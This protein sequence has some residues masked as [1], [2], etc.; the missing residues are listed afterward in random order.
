M[1]GP[2]DHFKE[3]P[4]SPSMISASTPSINSHGPSFEANGSTVYPGLRFYGKV[5]GCMHQ[6]FLTT[7]EYIG[8]FDWHLVKGQESFRLRIGAEDMG[9][10][11]DARADAVFTVN[12]TGRFIMGEQSQDGNRPVENATVT[13]SD[14][15]MTSPGGIRHLAKM[16]IPNAQE[17]VP[18]LAAGW[19]TDQAKRVVVNSF[20][21]WSEHQPGGSLLNIGVRNKTIPGGGDNAPGITDGRTNLAT[22]MQFDGATGQVTVNLG[23]QS[24]GH[25]RNVNEG[26]WSY[27]RYKSVAGEFGM[28]AGPGPDGAALSFWDYGVNK[29]I[30]YANAA[31][32]RFEAPI[33]TPAPAGTESAITDN[34]RASAE[35]IR[36]ALRAYE[37]PNGVRRFGITPAAVNE[38][39]TSAGLDPAK[40]DFIQGDRVTI[41]LWAFLAAA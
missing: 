8:E 15:D 11:K 23:D 1:T 21:F 27:E 28:G 41:D 31:V 38:A 25:V 12:A 32:V 18:I 14:Y 36:S 35:R 19:A 40:Y 34:E 16:D 17:G 37:D 2:I 29:P 26:N 4:A 10:A 7:A 22:V 20:A 5:G 30:A 33:T 6:H 39:L 3:D 24:S 9:K 13:V